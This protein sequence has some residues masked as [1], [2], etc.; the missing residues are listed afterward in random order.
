[1]GHNRVQ[2]HGGSLFMKMESINFTGK[3][4]IWTFDVK[5]YSSENLIDWKDEDVLIN[6]DTEKKVLT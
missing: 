5:Y 1:M 2:A 4:K 3:N 6:P